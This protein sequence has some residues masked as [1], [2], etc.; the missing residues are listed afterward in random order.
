[1]AETLH[2]VHAF[3][4]SACL[5]VVGV[6]VV[7]SLVGVLQQRAYSRWH[8][9]MARLNIGVNHLQMMVG[10]ILMTHSANVAFDGRT[11]SDAT[12]RLWTV[13]HPGLMMAGI[14]CV[15]LALIVVRRLTDDARKHR[16]S[17]VFNVAASAFYGVG[18]FVSGLV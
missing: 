8:E 10:I 14:V 2:T 4:R 6:A 3:L 18:L 9:A 15:T 1:M 12:I 5:V 17:L 7:V 13:L 11:M 16:F